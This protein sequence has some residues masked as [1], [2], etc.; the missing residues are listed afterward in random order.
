MEELDLVFLVRFVCS[1]HVGFMEEERE[2]ECVD[3][4]CF[5]VD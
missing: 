4:E 1:C 2:G 5:V 3:V